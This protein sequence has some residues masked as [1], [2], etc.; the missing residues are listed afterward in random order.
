VA[1]GAPCLFG[2]EGNDS[3]DSFDVAV[4]TGVSDGD[5]GPVGVSDGCG[6]ARVFCF[7]CGEMVGEGEG[8]GEA[9]F[10]FGAGEGDS[11]SSSADGVFFFFGEGV[12]DG[13]GDSLSRTGDA[14]FLGEG[15][16]VG[17]FFFVA[18]VLFFFRG[19]GVGV[20]VAKIFLIASPNDCS[21]A[22]VG[23]AVETA[24]TIINMMRT[25][26]AKALTDWRYDFLSASCFG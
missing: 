16:G 21:A 1:L 17:D 6:V 10:F 18:D 3:G 11:I 20:G 13:V 14:F 15:V 22:R 7:R 24:S 9:F 19:F 2:A 23:K 25:S 4:G 12:T 26:I 8:V 5:V